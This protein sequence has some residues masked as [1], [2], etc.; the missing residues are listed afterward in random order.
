M[1]IFDIMYDSVMD[2]LGTERVKDGAFT[3]E[4]EVVSLKGVPCKVSQKFFNSASN[5][6]YTA[7][8]YQIKLFC[9]TKYKIKAGSKFVVTDRNG[10]VKTFIAANEPMTHHKH[11]QEIPVKLEEKA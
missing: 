6:E 9:H 4:K 11:H 5:G 10:N 8:G 3:V 1:A 2:V 7:V